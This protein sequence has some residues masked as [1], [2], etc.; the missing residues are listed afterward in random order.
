MPDGRTCSSFAVHSQNDMARAKR[1]NLL[2]SDLILSTYSLHSMIWH[3]RF[4]SFFGAEQTL[5]GLTED[6]WTG[7]EYSSP[8]GEQDFTDPFLRFLS[9]RNGSVGKDVELERK[10]VSGIGRRRRRRRRS[11]ILVLPC[12]IDY[13]HTGRLVCA[14]AS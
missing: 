5:D 11:L 4:Q 13:S 8:P 9:W 12:R 10:K 6:P 1:S 7:D 14:R 2:Y 3:E